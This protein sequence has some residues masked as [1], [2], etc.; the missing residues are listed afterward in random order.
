MA[1]EAWVLWWL[2][3][4]QF[5]VAYWWWKGPQLAGTRVIVPGLFVLNGI[6]TLGTSIA[7][8]APSSAFAAF[9]AVSDRWTN[10]FLLG[11]GL[12]A[13]PPQSQWRRA[14]PA[15]LAIAALALFVA[16]PPTA[17]GTNELA[18]DPQLFVLIIELPLISGMLF[19]VMAL[20]WHSSSKALERDSRAWLLVL[21]AIGIR[22]AELAIVNFLPRVLGYGPA[23]GVTGAINALAGLAI[24]VGMVFG[25]GA[26]L[27]FRQGAAGAT[28]RTLDTVAG[29]LLA[30]FLVG[31]ARVGQ[32]SIGTAVFFTLAFI[33]PALFLA[34]QAELTGTGILRYTRGR[35]VAVGAFVF[36]TSSVGLLVAEGL[37]GM[38]PL[39]SLSIAGALALMAYP[40]GVRLV[41]GIVTV[42]EPPVSRPLQQRPSRWP[43]EAD[44]IRLPD[45]WERTVE[46]NFATYQVLPAQT[47]ANLAKLARWQRLLL[48]ID[49]IP[50]G[51]PQNT[52]QRTTPGL[53]LATHCPY[54][55]IG[56][57]ISR[58][59]AR[60][61]TILGELGI[62]V[63]GWVSTTKHALVQD[64]WGQAEGL[65]SGR[66]K[67]YAAT[68]LGKQVAER[69]RAMVGLSDLSPGEVGHM[70]AEG[71][72]RPGA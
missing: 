32:P 49:A 43:I 14:G 7:T 52:F 60:C 42:A 56:S 28:R 41:R 54:N 34:A 22:Y 40:A 26:V 17:T 35:D 53:H 2:A 27:V 36:V 20:L 65:R 21:A 64:T 25:F 8:L 63:P 72:G 39:R 13:L 59:N 6:A 50:D 61:K 38:G 3:A 1:G 69:I 66:V 18:G 47:R 62:P 51:A 45:G 44:R 10:L 15:L 5:A 71:F 37:W 33:R 29:F 12:A 11:V 46:E 67:L 57:E 31:A 19:A 55:S 4:L 48:A 9:A 68:P 16:T 30:G 23:V 58:A 24:F 70:V